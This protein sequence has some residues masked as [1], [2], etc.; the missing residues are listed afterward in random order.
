MGP[1]EDLSRPGTTWFP[2]MGRKVFGWWHIVSTWYHEAVPGHHLQVATTK[3][4]LKGLIVSKEIGSGFLA[5]EKVGLY[6]QNG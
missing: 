2:T 4:K 3:V 1:S 6:T 5:M